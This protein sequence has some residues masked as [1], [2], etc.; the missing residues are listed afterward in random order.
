MTPKITGVCLATFVEVTR[1]K[2]Q[3]RRSTIFILP[4]TQPTLVN[5]P[6][7]VVWATPETLSH[8]MSSMMTS[9][10]DRVGITERL[11][12]FP[13]HAIIRCPPDRCSPAIQASNLSTVRETSDW[14]RQRTYLRMKLRQVFLARKLII[15]SSLALHEF[16]KC[17]QPRC[18]RLLNAILSIT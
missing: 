11:P 18:D 6:K 17:K 3:G 13:G 4:T 10:S 1:P 8:T 7:A 15:F 16:A 2:C 5:A 12:K 9:I 14:V